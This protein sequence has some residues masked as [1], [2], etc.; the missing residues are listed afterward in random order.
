MS[1]K[2]CVSGYKGKIGSKL[3]IYLK[4]KF[5]IYPFKGNKKSIK[6]SKIFIDF[7]STSNCINNLKLLRN[8]KIIIGTTGFNKKQLSY[9]KKKSNENV[10]FLE[11]N[12]N[13][14]FNIFLKIIK[15]SYLFLNKKNKFLIEFHRKKKKDK[16]S[17]SALK[18]LK[19]I[20]KKKCFSVRAGDIY[21]KHSLYYFDKYNEIS[22]IHNVLSRNAFFSNMKNIITFI[23]KKKI[24]IY[25]ND[26]L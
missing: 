5:K 16:P 2:I 26:D 18:I 11:Y 3:I 19:I 8:K 12:M 25:N 6:K 15:Y 13:Y 1:V 21:G 14:V 9:I 22:I 4:K 20:K 7:S 24:G 10:I 17:G 23:M